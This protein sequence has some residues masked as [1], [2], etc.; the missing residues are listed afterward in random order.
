M[1]QFLENRNVINTYYV[2]TS[3]T[4]DGA[5]SA[6]PMSQADFVTLLTTIANYS[7]VYLKAGDTFRGSFTNNKRVT[8]DS[9]GV[10]ADPII[11]GSIDISGQ[12]W[13]NDSGN[14]WYTVMAQV[15]KTVFQ[16]GTEQP[17]AET[18]FFAISARTA[19]NAVSSTAA[20]LDTYHSGESLVG[21]EIVAKEFGFK[22]T[23]RRTVTAWDG[24]ILTLDSQIG[25]YNSD[26]GTYAPST[27]S[28]F[29]LMNHKNFITDIG[30]WCYDAST[31]R[32][33]ILTS[34]GAPTNIFACVHNYGITLSDEIDYVTI[35]NI[36][37]EH[38]YLA[39]IYSYSNN[40]CTFT[41]NT[42]INQ[43]YD[44]IF[45]G[46]NSRNL[47]ISYSAFSN[48]AGSG[49]QLGGIRGTSIITRNTFSNIGMQD[50]LCPLEYE[51]V[52]APAY[53]E[54]YMSV[55]CGIL[56]FFDFNSERGSTIDGLEISYN[57]IANTGYSS[58]R[59]AGRNLNIHHNIVSESCHKWNDGGGIYLFWRPFGFSLGTNNN[60]IE[61]NIVK[62][63]QGSADTT[64]GLTGATKG[65]LGIYL[66]NGSSKTTVRYNTVYNI[67]TFTIFMNFDTHE[68]TVTDNNCMG[69]PVAVHEFLDAYATNLQKVSNTFPHVEEV[70][71]E[72]NIIGINRNALVCVQ[73]ANFIAAAFN[74]FS[75][76]GNSD[77]NH[78]VYPY[79]LDI[80]EH[81]GSST[82]G[83]TLAEWQTKNSDDASSTARV[84]YITFSSNANADEEIK[85]E[86]NETEA[87]VNFNVPAGYTDYSGAAFSNPVAIAAY[88]SLLYFKDTAFP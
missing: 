4:G 54:F 23:N 57:T 61:Y 30:E 42:F 76:P 56:S 29:K 14:I 22:P 50:W 15:P 43:H 51:S 26:L 16:N 78:Y 27:S 28:S 83:Y 82:V 25:L 11:S 9:F 65:I 86:V 55:A 46:G 5:T 77:N 8:F 34:G 19:A 85:I 45:A 58:M 35:Q 39:G 36:Q 47:T 40:F 49:I 80:A 12:T 13:T 2:S 67:Y 79:G 48:M 32:L 31:Q 84:N 64:E 41:S 60:T 66:D 53:R 7:R 87:S 6:T 74:P 21:A 37:F 62:N 20:A 1:S 88:R 63:H 68:H 44:G 38:Q 72:N 17:K 69:Q 52:N 18:E 81:I 71:L 59:L 33:Y 10:G 73:T 75:T 70:V 24:T 3:G